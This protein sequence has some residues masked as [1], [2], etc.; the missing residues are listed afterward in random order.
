MIGFTDAPLLAAFAA[1]ARSGSFSAAARALDLSK[2]V[3]STRV[4]ELERRCGA[5]LLE[6]TTRRVRLTD[7]GTEALEVAARIDESLAALSRSLE[8]RQREPSGVLRVSTTG[9]LGTSLVAPA[10]ARLVTAFPKLRVEILS[11]DAALD[12]LEKGVDVAVRLGSPKP[13]SFVARRLAVL[14]EPIVAAPMLAERWLAARRPAD[15]VAAPWVRHALVTG[16]AMRFVGPSGATQE[17]SPA[18]RAVAN[19]GATILSLLLAGAGLGVMPE[20]VLREPL[21][22]GRLVELC[23]GWIWKHVTLYALMPAGA[24]R[25]PAT[26]ELLRLLLE[27]MQLEERRWPDAPR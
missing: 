1:V 6:R 18:F 4:A 7:A 26:K 5:A 21:R 11:D 15:L 2:S 27:Q 12:L 3:I 16:H 17:I 8:G 23:P 13:S 19:A 25:N 9:D 22:D 24:R 14:R 10:V 20:H